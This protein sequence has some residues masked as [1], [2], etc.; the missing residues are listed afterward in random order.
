[1]ACGSPP[2]DRPRR[3]GWR[4]R[5]RRPSSGSLSWPGVL[6]QWHGWGCRWWVWPCR[7]WRRERS[8]R[9]EPGLLAAEFLHLVGVGGDVERE[10]LVAAVDDE[11]VVFDPDSQP[12]ELGG[13]LELDLLGLF[14]RL[15]LAFPSCR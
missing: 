1:A 2:W 7:P 9:K 13:H 12:H 6:R 10:V 4:S 15:L 14:Q 8:A 11:D 5:P 3:S